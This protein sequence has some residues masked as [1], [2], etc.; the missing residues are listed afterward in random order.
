MN[1]LGPKE[2]EDPYIFNPDRCVAEDGCDGGH[3]RWGFGVVY[4]VCVG[5]NIAMQTIF[6]CLIYCLKILYGLEL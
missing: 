1:Y 4:R 6:S 5:S 2:H 3:G